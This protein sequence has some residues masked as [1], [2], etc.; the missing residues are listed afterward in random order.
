MAQLFTLAHIHTTLIMKYDP[1][2]FG[3][4]PFDKIRNIGIRD[5]NE[6]LKYDITVNHTDATVTHFIEF[7]KGRSATITFK[8]GSIVNA[9]LHNGLNIL[10]DTNG[11]IQLTVAIPKV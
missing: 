11:N 2:L 4:L 8:T 5:L 10:C 3:D 7:D 1:L 9:V 6:V